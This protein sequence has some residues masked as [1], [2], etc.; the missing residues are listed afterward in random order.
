MT[1]LSYKKWAANKKFMLE[2]EP[3]F[4]YS[5][6][7]D[8]NG[9]LFQLHKI[10]RLSQFPNPSGFHKQEHPARNDKVTDD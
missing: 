1:E 2:L 10:N 3:V 5:W 7:F 8:N 6:L 4:L 9:N